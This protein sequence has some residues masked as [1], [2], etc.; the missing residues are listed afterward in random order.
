MTYGHVYVASVA[1]GCLPE[2]TLRAFLEAGRI[3]ALG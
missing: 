3:R 2:Q 1:I